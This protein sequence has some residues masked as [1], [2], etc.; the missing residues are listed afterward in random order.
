MILYHQ[1]NTQVRPLSWVTWTSL[2]HSCV[3]TLN[4][5]QYKLHSQSFRQVTH[6][7]HYM[8]PYFNAQAKPLLT[9]SRRARSSFILLF[10]TVFAKHSLLF[11]FFYKYS[12]IEAIAYI[13]ELKDDV[14][15]FCRLP[16]ALQ[17]WGIHI[18]NSRRHVLYE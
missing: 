1:V 5:H 16:I 3:V 2:L 10:T 9:S 15:T 11:T 14:I 18:C 4:T 8:G 13:Q 12:E 7:N 6:Q 17:S